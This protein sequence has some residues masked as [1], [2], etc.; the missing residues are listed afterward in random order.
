MWSRQ[1]TNGKY[2][3]TESYKDPI[4]G[5]FKEV[6]VTVG[7]NTKM[8]QAQARAIL[9]KKIQQKTS[10]QEFYKNITFE[11]V[12]NEWLEEYKVTVT[13]A[14]HTNHDI[15]VKRIIKFLPEGILLSAI[16]V[17]QLRNLNRRLIESKKYRRR[18]ISRTI[19]QVKRI[20]SYATEKGYIP[21]SR[22]LEK[23]KPL[24]SP[25]TE[26]EVQAANSKYL[27][28]EEVEECLQQLR[29]ID[30]R[31]ALIAEFQ[32]RTGV[33]IGE[34]LALREQDY[35]KTENEEGEI[36]GRINVNGSMEYQTKERKPPKTEKSIRDVT[37]GKRTIEILDTLIEENQYKKKVSSNKDFNNEGY[38]FITLNESMTNRG[39]RGGKPYDA[40]YINKKLSLLK[41]S[42]KKITSHIFRHTHISRLAEAGQTIPAIMA[43]VGHSDS[44]TT[45]E[46]YMHVTNKMKDSIADIEDII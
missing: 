26:K 40:K 24:N 33:R 10:P 42:N 34:L 32:V 13:A 18:T 5:R 30:T 3:F 44:K 21:Y 45:I 31:L 36:F 46:I 41:V 27:E 1:Q 8:Y 2:K 17:N 38:I 28:Y 43:R 37:I 19:A 29:A 4:T 16:D 39:R 9:T 35:I 15:A 20:I 7:G 22:A 6:S 23:Y 25:I 11:A 14:T 12:A